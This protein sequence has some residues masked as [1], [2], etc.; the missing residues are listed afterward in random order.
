MKLKAYAI[1]IHVVAILLA[2]DVVFLTYQ[3]RQLK[4]TI[5]SINGKQ[6]AVGDTLR[7]GNLELVNGDD[8]ANKKTDRIVFI[9]STT[10]SKCQ[11]SY[12]AWSQISERFKNKKA[13]VFGI[14]VD[15]RPMVLG[16]IAK[17]DMEFSVFVPNDSQEFKRRNSISFVPLSLLLSEDW[18]VRRIW[19]GALEVKNLDEFL[20]A[21]PD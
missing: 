18:I 10:C 13:P 3:N 2:A 15:T 12:R 21:V 20:K 4:Q 14:C 17:G 7:V 11:L 9:F 6:L 8:V 5:S 19:K 1:A 16:E